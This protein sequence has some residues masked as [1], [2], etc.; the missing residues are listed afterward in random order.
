MRV[1]F[2][3][4]ALNEKSKLTVLRLGAT[5]EGTLRQHKITESGRFRDSVY[6][7]IID[8]EWEKVKQ[9]LERKLRSH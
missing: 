7:S 9:N 6:F 5:E 2:K 8:L 4:D 1:E 3:T